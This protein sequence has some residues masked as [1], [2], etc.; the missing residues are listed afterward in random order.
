[1]RLRLKPQAARSLVNEA[2]VRNFA[3]HYPVINDGAKTAARGSLVNRVQISATDDRQVGKQSQRQTIMVS[4][5]QACGWR[6]LFHTNTVNNRAE[7]N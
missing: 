2:V 6:F 1:M 5:A 7:L 4:T 3:Y